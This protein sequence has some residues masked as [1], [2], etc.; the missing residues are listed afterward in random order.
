VRVSVFLVVIAALFAATYLLVPKVGSGHRYINTSGKI[1]YLSDSDSPGMDHVW[2]I[3]SDGSEAKDLTPG[4]QS[5]TS[6]T[7]S[8]DGSQIAYVSDKGGEAQV[9]VMD[10]DGKGAHPVTFGSSSKQQPKFSPDGKTLTYLTLGTLTALDLQSNDTSPLL[11]SPASATSSS[12]S[13]LSEIEQ[14]PVISY[15]WSPNPSSNSSSGPAIAAVQEVDNDSLPQALRDLFGDTDNGSLQVLTLL[16]NMDATPKVIAYAPNITVAWSPD[17]S[18]IYAAILG[19]KGG[20]QNKDF[21]GIV[22]FTA[23]GQPIQKP[24]LGL[25][26]S[27]T[28]GPTD[29]AISPDG[30]KVLFTAI[31]NPDLAHQQV[32]GLFTQPVD[33]SA[34][35]TELIS[36][37]ASNVAYSPDGNRLLTLIPGSDPQKRDLWVGTLGSSTGPVNLTKGSG[38]VTYAEWSPTLAKTGS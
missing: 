37:D 14:A 28:M 5:C 36:G 25:S 7:F 22:S 23:D 29:P 1:I 16:P 6:P 2:I 11:P 18:Q 31:N 8:P 13:D 4:N 19:G 12:T 34:P 33:A 24:P 35:P 38:N 15:S 9:Y 17:G 27:G 21:S 30:T 26:L 32:I 10:A 20:P 3:N